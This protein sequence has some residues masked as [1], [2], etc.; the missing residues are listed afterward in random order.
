MEMEHV[1][2]TRVTP[3]KLDMTLFSVDIYA[4]IWAWILSSPK[5]L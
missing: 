1:H 2:G 5:I 3:L 4:H